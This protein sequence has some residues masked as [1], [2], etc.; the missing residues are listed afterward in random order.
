MLIILNYQG[1]S[2]TSLFSFLHSQDSAVVSLCERV[3]WSAM[4]NQGS[5]SEG[6]N[7]IISEKRS[8]RLIGFFFL[9]PLHFCQLTQIVKSSF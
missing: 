8:I 1:F 3:T 4:Y 9:L 5:G 6:G 7:L 2:R